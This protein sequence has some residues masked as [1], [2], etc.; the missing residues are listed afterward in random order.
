MIGLSTF[1]PI[2]ERSEMQDRIVTYK[3]SLSKEGIHDV[4]LAI[5][6][7]IYVN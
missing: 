3:A 7:T 6:M 1:N 5:Q 4:I 2:D